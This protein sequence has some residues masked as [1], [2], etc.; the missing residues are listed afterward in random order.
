MDAVHLLNDY[1]EKHF[2]YEEALLRENQYPKLEEHIEEHRKIAA[3]ISRL[4]EKIL[5]GSDDI[6]QEFVALIREWITTHIGIE[7][8]EFGKAFAIP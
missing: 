3:E 6:D 4:T 5:Q 8:V 1:V 2:S 7:D